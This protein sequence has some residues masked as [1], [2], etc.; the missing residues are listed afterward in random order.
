MQATVKQEASASK[1]TN[2]IFIVGSNTNCILVAEMGSKTNIILVAELVSNTNFILV[3][4]V[5]SN[6]YVILVVKVGSDT[7]FILV[8][9]WDPIKVLY[10]KQKGDRKPFLY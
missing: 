2:Y 7:D 1:A 6:T 10:W 9:K 8:Q 4:N 3:K 5:G